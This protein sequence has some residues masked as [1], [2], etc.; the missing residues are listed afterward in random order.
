MREHL[1]V[2][3]AL[4]PTGRL[5]LKMQQTPYTG[6]DIVKFLKVLRRRIKGK[7]MVI[8]DGAPIH[9]A[10]EVKAYLAGGAARYFQL[11]R[12]PGYAPELNPDEGVWHLLKNSELGN[13]CCRT[14]GELVSKLQVALRR[15]GRQRQVL[16]KCV[17]SY[18]FVL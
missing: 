16:K 1:N 9:Q 10:K 6:A 11:E 4:S 8:W 12:L 7:I 2:I 5:F 13:V 3:S 15:L 18:G 14:F 17:A